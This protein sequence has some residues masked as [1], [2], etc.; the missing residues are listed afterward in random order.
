MNENESAKKR[1]RERWIGLISFALLPWGVSL[2][3]A[4]ASARLG[5]LPLAIER[6]SEALSVLAPVAGII[7]VVVISR[8]TLKKR[9]EGASLIL[10]IVCLITALMS[11]VLMPFIYVTY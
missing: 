6:R 1:F 10:P 11:I 7:S 9:R 8:V 2:L 4:V 5:L 3:G